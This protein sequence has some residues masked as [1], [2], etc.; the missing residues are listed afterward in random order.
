M[1]ILLPEELRVC[2]TEGGALSLG[3]GGARGSAPLRRIGGI[4][5]KL[6]DF[7]A[8]F[9]DDDGCLY[10]DFQLLDA[11]RMPGRLELDEILDVVHTLR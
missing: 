10:I 9:V 6:R 5:R 3:M 1:L 8:R 11:D 7:R 2:R 4:R